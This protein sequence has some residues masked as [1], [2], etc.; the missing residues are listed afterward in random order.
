MTG[1]CPCCWKM[2]YLEGGVAM[3]LLHPS[4]CHPYLPRPRPRHVACS[5]SISCFWSP[6]PWS[7]VP[8]EKLVVPQLVKFPA[9]YGS[10]TSITVFTAPRHLNLPR[11]RLIHSTPSHPIYLKSVLILSSHLRRGLPSGLSDHGYPPKPCMHFSSFHTCH[12]PRPSYS[13]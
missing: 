5:A 12:M 13:P 9:F 4:P 11:A 8:R 7:T 10:L 3:S 6:T 1:S 2:A